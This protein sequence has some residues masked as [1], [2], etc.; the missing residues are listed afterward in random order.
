[1]GDE[2]FAFGN[3]QIFGVG[4]PGMPAPAITAGEMHQAIGNIITVHEGHG[5]VVGVRLGF[6]AP[7]EPGAGGD[8][9]PGGVR[10]ENKSE[11]GERLNGGFGMGFV[12]VVDDK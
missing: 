10:V 2:V 7:G 11:R 9:Q 3:G 8:A 12:K 4:D 6:R 1:M 5:I